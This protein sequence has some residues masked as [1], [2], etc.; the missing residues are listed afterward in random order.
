MHVFAAYNGPL[1]IWRFLTRLALL[2]LVAG[3]SYEVLKALAHA[4]GKL[5]RALRWPGMQLQRIT[6]KEPDDKMLEIA[7]CSMNV[8]LYGM[9]K[10]VKADK[11][12]WV[13]ID[14]YKETE[15]GYEPPVAE[16]PVQE[17]EA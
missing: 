8:A 9:P 11:N 14:S 12:G 13:Y 1:F 4:D 3:V 15:P 7:I 5:V 16:E 6:T 2:P 10:H 17:A